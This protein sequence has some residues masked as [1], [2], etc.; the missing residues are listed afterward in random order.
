MNIQ[1]RVLSKAAQAQ[2]KAL[3]GRVAELETQLSAANKTATGGSMLGGVRQQAALTKWG[4]QLQWTGRQLQYN[5]TLPIVLAGAA[6]TKFAMDNEKAF[7]HVQKVYGDASAAAT[8]FRKHQELIPEGMNASQAATRTFNK[9]LGALRK[10][11][12]AMSSYYGVAQSDVLDV[13]G[14]WAA[15]GV[16]GAALAR[17]VNLT[18]KAIIIGDMDAAKATD[19]LISIQSQYGEN[20][21]QL[22]RDL[23]YM[24]AIENQTAISMPGLIEGFA[25]SAGVAREAGIDVR[26]LAAMMA[27]LVPATGSA[28]QAGN[29]L[30]TIIS[31]LMSPT[32]EATQ[33]MKAMG[34][35]IDKQAWQS[36]NVTDRLKMMADAYKNL[37]GEQKK[38]ISSQQGV[39]GSVIA[40]RW[41]INKFAVL[42]RA[43][44][45]P[46]S[47]YYQALRATSDEGKAFTIMQ[48][49]L[50]KVLNSSPRRL[51]IIWQ[52]LKNGMADAIQPMIPYILYMANLIRSLVNWF[53]NLT[54]AVQKLFMMMLLGLAI[55]GPLTRYFGSL[56]TLVGTMGKPLRLL[57]A[58]F[59]RVFVSEEIAAEG[60]TVLR[61]SLIASAITALAWPFRVVIA[62]FGAVGAAIVA[63]GRLL[64]LN[65]AAGLLWSK[66]WSAIALGWGVIWKFMLGKYIGFS[67]A[68]MR[69][70]GANTMGRAFL[71]S[72]Q[73]MFAWA[74]AT[75]I[76]G[77][78]K[79]AIIS[80]A[81][82]GG[83]TGIFSSMFVGLAGIFA[84]GWARIQAIQLASMVR[85]GQ[86]R[87]VFA[88]MGIWVKEMLAGVA[89]S[90]MRFGAALPVMLTRMQVALM[91]GMRAFGMA[92]LVFWDLL[93]AGISTLWAVMYVK[94][95]ALSARGGVVLSGVTS[96][97]GAALVALWGL[98]QR[99]ITAVLVAGR[100]AM[101]AVWASMQ[102][103][104]AMLSSA[105][106]TGMI[107]MWIFGMSTL[108]KMPAK[109][110]LAFRALG[111]MLLRLAPTL[112]R[113]ATGWVGLAVAAILGVLAIFHRQIAQIW[114]NIVR[115]FSDSSNGMVKAI[116]QGWNL[117]PKGVQSALS[118]VVRIVSAAA[119]QVYEWFSYLNPFAHHS[120]SLV[121]NVQKG[122]GQVNQHMDTVRQSGD[123]FKQAHKHAEQY[124]KTVATQHVS[125]GI[126][127]LVA[128]SQRASQASDKATIAKVSP[129]AAAEYGRLAKQVNALTPKLNAL[130]AAV[131][132]QQKAVDKAQAVVDMWNNKLE[133]AQKRLDAL[134]K[135]ADGFSTKIQNAQDAMST[136][137]STPLKGMQDMNDKIQANTMD[138]K[139]LQLQMM[140]MEKVTGP[141]D[142]VKSKIDAINGAQEL[143]R[144]EQSDLRAAGAGSDVLSGYDDQIKALD[145]TKQSYDTNLNALQD[146]QNQL[147]ALQKT[148]DELDLQKSLKFDDL[149]YQIEKASQ[150]MKEMPFD[151]IM[152]GIN[153]AQASIAKYT[154][155]LDAAN[156][157]V[158]RQQKVVDKLTAA[159]D[160]AQNHLDAEQK[161][162]DAVQKKYDAVNQTIQDL[163]QRMDD[164]AQAAQ[165][166]TDKMSGAGSK[167]KGAKSAAAAAYQSPGLKNFL[168]AKGGFFPD[169][170]GKGKAMRTDWKSQVPQIDKITEGLSKSTAKMFA[171]LNPFKPIKEK[172]NQ[173]TGWLHKEWKAL[174]VGF[175][176]MWNH[177]VAGVKSP[178]GLGS[179][180][181]RV[182]DALDKVW[183]KAKKFGGALGRLFGPDFKKIWN[184]LV[185][186]FESMWNDIAPE[187]G[188]FSKLVKPFG[189]MM[190]SLW[191]LA[192]P[193][194]KLLGGAFLLLAKIVVHTLSKVIG[195]V[196]KGIGQV[197][198]GAVRVI[199]GILE[200]L[201]GFL[202]GDW[203]LAW[204][205]I[206]DVVTGVWKIIWSVVGR[207][208]DIIENLIG[209]F[210]SSIWDFFKW[211]WDELVG[212]S[213][214]PD[215][216]NAIINTFHLLV[217]VPKW[218][219]KHVLK[220]VVDFFKDAWKLVAKGLHAWWKGLTAAW[221]KLKDAGKWIKQHVWQPVLDAAKWVWDRE[222]AGFKQWWT[223]IKQA[224]SKLKDLGKWIWDNVFVN[225][226]NRAKSLW[227]DHVKPSLQGWWAGIKSAWNNLLGLGKWVWDR[228]MTPVINKIKDGWNA[229]KD[230]LAKN[231]DMLMSP[232]N[233]VVN[234]V[235]SA[236]N[237]MIKGLNK[238]SDVLPGIDFTIS[239]IPKLAE[240]GE[241]AKRRVGS[242]FKTTGARAIVGEGKANYPE[243][244]IPTDPTHRRR[245]RMLHEM[246]GKK[247]GM[248][249]G[250]AWGENTH[251]K[252]RIINGLP[253]YDIGGILGNIGDIAKGTGSW[254]KGNVEKLATLPFAPLRALAQSQIDKVKWAPAHGIAQY[255]LDK[256]LSWVHLA[257]QDAAAAA[258]Q[259]QKNQA[260]KSGYHGTL[261]PDARIAKAQKFALSQVGDPYVWGGVGPNGFD[262]SGF[263]S[264][265]TNVLL[266]RNPYSRVGATSSF[267]WSGFSGGYS[268]KGFTIGSTNNYGG[269]GIG[270]MAGTLAGMNV[271][272]R[273]GTGVVVGSGARGWNDPGFS[274]NAHLVGLANGAI[275]RR[276]AGGIM[277]RI[278]EGSHD[279]AVTPLP[280]GWRGMSPNTESNKTEIHIHG[281]LSFPNITSP[282]DA[283]RF[284]ENLEILARD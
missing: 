102:V 82:G 23:A 73:R 9:E 222:V 147:D 174:S 56:M 133:A 269:S 148:A 24:N 193:V 38:M 109:I 121:E 202:T 11:F 6:A 130:S 15:A 28:S 36:A 60:G 44:N 210:V 68:F 46:L 20:T 198:G 4:N 219:W 279:E 106:W 100:T 29:A 2:I 123:A 69:W 201:I 159:R 173:F 267:P 110:F 35:Q 245:A 160:K 158:A 7:V 14:A 192:W 150:T 208:V 49:E 54:P 111:P 71:V 236:V 204:Q 243:F 263:M 252:H 176:D 74:S 215:M 143:L 33:V 58:G 134:Q 214:V 138:Q 278:G 83:L 277:A 237:Y 64:Q 230:W 84:A 191:S 235:V 31:R 256:V 88:A 85:M 91:A 177:A 151:Q 118:A 80:A 180:I 67:I 270:H 188:K 283:E 153:G 282:D 228:V 40:S 135:V 87:I 163:Q 77:W 22:A 21:K 175:S 234:A 19:A 216:V 72:V 76:A 248:Q 10:S 137:A 16:S 224:W 281:D 103:G 161:K 55:V 221:D 162:L 149:T 183:K 8:Y 190:K 239:L 273:G 127:A 166:L 97:M 212:H 170:G 194:I 51:A 132:H 189:K 169:V 199:R 196:M 257:D 139:K 96:R 104:M 13:A 108:I 144:G 45:N 184:E 187:I 86:I 57:A 156:A 154:P 171:D 140:Q 18:M 238:I 155:K 227:N 232:V 152:A 207:F 122:M 52:T 92:M 34:L 241:L 115:Y 178:Q 94:L 112:L 61:R 98:I 129:K 17:S 244:V 253:A 247:L 200:I 211:L 37:T 99:G 242:G 255:G 101:L 145:Q 220:P 5:W 205:G 62:A 229:V 167:K 206:V 125:G 120:P 213:I 126:D 186:G 66:A 249:N 113:A 181:T 226:W 25:R 48:S 124:S 251:D 63:T 272:S 280:R 157:A 1:V 275:I 119:K 197:I 39:A 141:L 70:A 131:E 146:M 81:G 105:F 53:S 254:I 114:D 50:N 195:P 268:A 233:G 30:K 117:L 90:V 142:D 179:F 79:L 185:G 12:E 266:G 240:G 250:G 223:W 116:L 274:T 164:A 218:I 203:A 59:V 262:C 107:R 261:S 26:H 136:Y 284:I 75:F 259:H 246:A 258:K 182:G 217:A 168:M 27:A 95:A 65:V 264:A 47:M 265:I 276:R 128:A 3:Q 32:E 93:T 41:Q 225:V 231:K 271:E 209:G 260:K 165:N 78:G 43:I 89:L 42:M 172:W